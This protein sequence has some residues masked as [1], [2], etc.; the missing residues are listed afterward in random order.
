MASSSAVR[1]M[2][3][4]TSP[5]THALGPPSTHAFRPPRACEGCRSLKV[6]CAF[7][8][9]QP[10]TCRR[11]IKARRRCVITER[12]KRRVVESSVTDLERKL[13]DLS[14]DLEAIKTSSNQVAG[15][16]Q[17]S[18]SGRNYDAPGP[19]LASGGNVPI[20]PKFDFGKAPAEMRRPGPT[21]SSSQQNDSSSAY[22]G[23]NLYETSTVSIDADDVID[24]E[25]LS[26]YEQ[27]MNSLPGAIS[28]P[29]PRASQGVNFNARQQWVESGDVIDQGLLTTQ[30]AFAAFDHFV[31][32]TIVHFPVVAFPPG[33]TAARM[34][35][36]KPV[37]FL[38][39][40]GAAC[41]AFPVTV[42]RQI[43]QELMAVFADRIIRIGEKSLELI[44]AVSIAMIWYYPPGRYEELK[45]YQLVCLPCCD[46]QT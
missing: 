43:I 5:H 2:S 26:T 12:R 27:Q 30:A 8:S 40:L 22:R 16:Q 19:T 15:Q 24:S 9:S 44:Q 32:N 3:D 13:N 25:N 21:Q 14:A 39:I 11:C 6:Q 17:D 28:L 1:S 41:G 35:Q 23:S 29:A 34:R 37:L 33:I 31:S 42:Q 46:S 7:D 18:S 38:A 36:M 20:G 45:Y 10:S 4:D